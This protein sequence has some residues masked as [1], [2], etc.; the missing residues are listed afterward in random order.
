MREFYKSA[1]SKVHPENE[2][3]VV[4]SVNERAL[5]FG[6]EPIAVN[7]AL[8]ITVTGNKDPDHSAGVDWR[9]LRRRDRS[10]SVFL[11]LRCTHSPRQLNAKDEPR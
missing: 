4:D 1:N 7:R 10:S 3:R 6:H 11:V 9:R 2:L 5:D 8:K